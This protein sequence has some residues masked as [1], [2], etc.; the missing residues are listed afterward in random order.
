MKSN[1]LNK[2]RGDPG[3]RHRYDMEI[4]GPKG[5]PKCPRYLDKVAK[6]EWKSI[7][8]LLDKMGILSTI[9]RT[10]LEI[11]CAAYSRYRQAEIELQKNGWVTEDN[12]PNAWVAIQN[13]AYDVIK[14]FQDRFV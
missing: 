4:K 11:Y 12:K 1:K 6:E 10:A 5:L 2:L 7:V 13:R 14:N 8:P 9:D 3:K